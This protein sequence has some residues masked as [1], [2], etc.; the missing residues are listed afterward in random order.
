MSE[1]SDLSS[2]KEKKR[3]ESKKPPIGRNNSSISP[4]QKSRSFEP[5]PISSI[6]SMP[7]KPVIEDQSALYD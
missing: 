2:E 6:P 5:P 3:A 4:N 7:V 1:D